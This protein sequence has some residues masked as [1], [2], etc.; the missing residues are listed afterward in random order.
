L[1]V[2]N[3]HIYA[4]DVS[5]AALAD[6]AEV[7]YLNRQPTSFTLP[8]EAVDR[9]RAAAGRIIEASPEFRRLLKD[10]GARVLAPS[11]AQGAGASGPA[12][13]KP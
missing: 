3:A 13:K 4:I 2:P 9:L 1:R 6:E 11:P 7:D 10:T 12:V 8:D 5:F